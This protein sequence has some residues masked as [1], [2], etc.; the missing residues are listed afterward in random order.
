MAQ[1]VLISKATTNPATEAQDYCLWDA[2]TAKYIAS[3]R[4]HQGVV[5]TGKLTK[6][7]LRIQGDKPFESMTIE[8][9]K[10]AKLTTDPWKTKFGGRINP[11]YGQPL[12][13][14]DFVVETKDECGRTIQIK[15]A[16]K[17]GTFNQVVNKCMTPYAG[18]LY[19]SI[20]QG[21]A[22]QGVTVSECP[23]EFS[24]SLSNLDHDIVCGLI[25][26]TFKR[27]EETGMKEPTFWEVSFDVPYINHQMKRLSKTNWVSESDWE[28][29][30]DED[31]V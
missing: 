6:C 31:E 24:K 26:T 13:I 15:F 12:F 30:D 29:E 25:P 14:H 27:N 19:G 28:E 3:K 20:V 22:G 4:L 23:L 16:L 11:D 1:K 10:Q 21:L 9:K 2:A 17:F 8:E 5:V 7:S 18:E